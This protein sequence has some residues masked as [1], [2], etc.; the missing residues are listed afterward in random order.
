MNK[1][2]RFHRIIPYDKVK[3]NRPRSGAFRLRQNKPG[4]SVY[5]GA[6]TDAEAAF[7]HW[8][9]SGLPRPA[10]IVSFTAETCHNL[11]ITIKPNPIEPPDHP[12]PFPQHTLLI[13][14]PNLKSNSQRNRVFQKLLAATQFRFSYRDPDFIPEAEETANKQAE[15]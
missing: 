11:G 12:I 10:G 7:R 2:R 8:I 3:A 1:D 9:N 13:P 6:D 15:Q 5:D 14:P 4:L